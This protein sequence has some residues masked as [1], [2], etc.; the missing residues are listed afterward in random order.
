M[1]KEGEE[2]KT[3]CLQT[4]QLPRRGQG[5]RGGGRCEGERGPAG[6]W[7]RRLVTFLLL[8]TRVLKVLWTHKHGPDVHTHTARCTQTSVLSPHTQAQTLGHRKHTITSSTWS[9]T[10]PHPHPVFP[11]TMTCAHPWAQMLMDTRIC[12][13]SRPSAVEA[14]VHGQL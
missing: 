10:Q 4:G 7:Q 5:G 6:D 3:E 9:G 1:A 12:R 14:L 13:N 8:H 2:R 11:R